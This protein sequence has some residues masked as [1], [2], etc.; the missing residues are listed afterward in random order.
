ML[1][2]CHSAVKAALGLLLAHDGGSNGAYC[3]EGVQVAL[4]AQGHKEAQATA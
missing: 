3:A 1:L 4:L 2:G